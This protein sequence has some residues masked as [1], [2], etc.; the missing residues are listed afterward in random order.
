MSLRIC[1]VGCGAFARLCHG[2][3]QR[4]YV[5]AHPDTELAGC[6]DSDPASAREF[7]ERFGYARAH[8]DVAA[9]LAAEKPDAV[10]LAVPPVITP[11]AAGLVLERGLPLLLEKPPGLIRAQLDRLIA[12]QAV[13]GR[14]QVAFNRR[15]MPVM[16]QAQALLERELPAPTVARI[17][18]D[19]VRCDRWDPDFS[20]TAIHAVDAVLFLA[21]SP[22]RTAELRFQEQTQ[23]G[24]VAVNF[25]LEAECV[26]GTR[27]W[28]NV[29]PVAGRNAESARIQAVGHSLA[30][31]IP[32][33]PTAPEPG[34]LEHWRGNRRAT[35]YSDPDG[36][37]VE[38]M[39]ITGELEA[40]LD[41][42]R[43]GG[44]MTP[45][46]RDCRQQV[47]LM[48]AIRLRRT[49]VLALDAS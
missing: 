29:Q 1:M 33:S 19:L 46:L 22:F 24:R 11:A 14:A 23:G 20:T 2:P 15:Y 32:A 39:G 8:T 44:P 18:Y 3:A 49:G 9:M 21:R 45:G 43:T 38:R 28:L 4:R 25:V 31:T 12:T 47:A 35:A 7:A 30:L 37:M 5:D 48:E 16:R 41:A 34:T 27:V 42:V 13:P 36:A 40:F 6:C 17:D 10:V 26:S